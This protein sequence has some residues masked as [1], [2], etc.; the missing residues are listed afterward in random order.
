MGLRQGVQSLRT[1]PASAMRTGRLR[2]TFAPARLAGS[3]VVRWSSTYLYFGDR[4][5]ARRKQAV[6]RTA[7][8]VTRT[9]GEMKGAAMKV[10]QVLS[11]MSGIL[12]DEMATELASLQ[13]NAPPMAYPL[14][15]EVFER[16]HGKAPESL[17]KSFE[18][19]PFAAAS[20]AQVH[21]AT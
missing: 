5:R 2:R 6:I 20:I 19:E 9:M 7:E 17:F 11:L 14:V 3:A 12:P 1:A 10:G 4:R 18:R 8:D 15:R 21:R 16:E 13:S